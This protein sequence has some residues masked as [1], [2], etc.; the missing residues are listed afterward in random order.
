MEEDRV[1]VIDITQL[2]EESSSNGSSKVDRDERWM[3]FKQRALRIL[4]SPNII[5]VAIGVV[6]AMISPLQRMLF[7]NPRAVLRPLGAAF[8][9]S[10]LFGCR[11]DFL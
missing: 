9:A 3:G 1:V 8:E 2:T 11:V 7:D 4:Q 6:I 10:V 5:A